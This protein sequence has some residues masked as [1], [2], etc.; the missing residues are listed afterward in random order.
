V[1]QAGG[2]RRALVKEFR[3]VKVD[4]ELTVELNPSAPGSVPVLCG[5][6]LIAQ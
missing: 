4:A 3:D 6:E 2:P 5:I 1:A